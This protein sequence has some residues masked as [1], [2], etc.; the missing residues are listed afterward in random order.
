[1]GSYNP[2][3]ICV[4]AFDDLQQRIGGLAAVTLLLA[5]AKEGPLGKIKRQ[6]EQRARLG[7]RGH[8]EMGQ[9]GKANPCPD[10]RQH[11]FV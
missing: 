2:V 4:E 6:G 8:H 7:R 5:Q 10:S 3:E 1:M 9:H 11:R